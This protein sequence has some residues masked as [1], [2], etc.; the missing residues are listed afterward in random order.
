MTKNYVKTHKGHKVPDGA[1]HYYDSDFDGF[2][3]YKMRKGEVYVYDENNTDWIFCSDGGFFSYSIHLPEATEQDLPNW[4]E[5]PTDTCVWIVDNNDVWV[6]GW[7]TERVESGIYVGEGSTCDWP[8][9]SK[10]ITVHK[11][12]IAI[13]D[14]GRKAFEQRREDKEWLPTVGEECDAV[15]LELPDGGGSDFC[16]VVIKGYCGNEVWFSKVNGVDGYSEVV[17]ITDCEFRPLK[18]GEELE[19]EDF[20]MKCF[21]VAGDSGVDTD[22]PDYKAF[23]GGLY[24]AGFTAPKEGE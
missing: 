7:Y 3:F 12:P 20:E 18:T 17:K 16:A 21:I 19:R 1:T 2:L 5:A 4:N 14:K 13:E 15:W 8:V 22:D 11:R 9:D 6:S 24:K 10:R 23:V